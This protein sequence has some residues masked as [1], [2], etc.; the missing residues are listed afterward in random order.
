LGTDAVRENEQIIRRRIKETIEAEKTDRNFIDLIQAGKVNTYTNGK[1]DDGA[2][3][4]AQ[5]QEYETRKRKHAEVL[6]GLLEYAG[7]DTEPLPWE[8]R[9]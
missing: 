1:K 2:E 5:Y 9:S 3:V 8:R 6:N 7:L 4:V